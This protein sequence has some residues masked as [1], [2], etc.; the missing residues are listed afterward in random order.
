M[1][2]GREKAG[3]GR[4]KDARKA[5]LRRFGHVQGDSG[6][7]GQRISNVEL[8]WRTCRDAG[9]ADEPLWRA[10]KGAAQRRGGSSN[11]FQL[12]CQ[13]DV[14]QLNTGSNY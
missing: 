9:E 5:R 13:Y 1:I 2:Y 4:I 14:S 10:L 12:Q 7:T 11:N 3:G 6:Y 8:Q